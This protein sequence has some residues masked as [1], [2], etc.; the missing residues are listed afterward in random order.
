MTRKL[1]LKSFEIMHK[2]LLIKEIRS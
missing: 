2:K 1:L